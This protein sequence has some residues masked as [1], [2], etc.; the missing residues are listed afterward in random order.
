MTN[1]KIL[2]TVGGAVAALSAIGAF[3]TGYLGLKPPRPAWF[4]EVQAVEARGIEGLQVVQA[5]VKS[6]TRGLKKREIRENRADII[7]NLNEQQ[8]F[9]KSAQQ[10][11]ARLILQQADLEE[12][13]IDLRDELNEMK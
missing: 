12:R 4:H 11:P 3:S 7:S 10:P 5:Q 2:L 1:L 13:A 9:T 8:A 6:N